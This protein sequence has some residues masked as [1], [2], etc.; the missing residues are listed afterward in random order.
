MEFSWCWQQ[1]PLHGVPNAD[2]CINEEWSHANDLL[3]V[4]LGVE[5]GLENLTINVLYGS[6]RRRSHVDG[7]EMSLE[8]V[9]NIILT[10]SWVKHCANELKVFNILEEAP[11]ILGKEVEALLLNQ[12]TSDLES[13]LITPSVNK[14]HGDIINE[15]R[16][17]L[18]S[19]RGEGLDL[20]LLNF[21]LD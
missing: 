5:D 17:L 20:L 2:G 19:W 10:T 21:S 6:L 11:L 4:L 15:D 16:H 12:L 3:T 9:R 13:D 7:E 8:S 1:S 14:R 18:A